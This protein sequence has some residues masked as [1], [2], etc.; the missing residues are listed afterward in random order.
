MAVNLLEAV[1]GLAQTETFR[2]GIVAKYAENGVLSRLPFESIVGDSYRWTMEAS[3]P[4]IANRAFNASYTEGT[5]STEE[6]MVS[7]SIFGGDI[8]VDK[9]IVGRYGESRRTQQEVMK[10]K[11]MNLLFE[12]QFFKGDKRSTPE[13]INGLQYYSDFINTDNKIA[14]GSTSGGDALSLAKLDEAIAYTPGANAIFCN[15]DMFIRFQKAA[16]TTTVAGNIMWAPNEFGRFVLSYGGLPIYEVRNDN[17][18]NAILP[19]TE[20]NPGGGTAASTSIY[21][22]RFGSDGVFGIMDGIPEVSDLGEIDAKPVFRTRVDWMAAVVPVA[23]DS[24]AR[25]Y[26]IKNAAITA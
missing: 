4:T 22:C 15:T 9:K 18:G 3:L 26:G 1:K 20:A 23:K 5:G 10:L 11:A 25:V 8:D 12:K 17:A 21:V 7:L 6:H 19:F 14:A 24:Y 13:G 2:A 16:R